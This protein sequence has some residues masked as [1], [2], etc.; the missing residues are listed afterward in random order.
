[1][2]PFT[3]L[4]AAL[5]VVVAA[6]PVAAEPI[7]LAATPVALNPDDPA[8]REVGDLVYRGGFELVS[9]DP[10]F[11]GFSALGVSADGGRMVALS[12][13]GT[14]LAARLTYDPD[15][16]LSG[17][18]EPDLVPLTD[19][20]GE[21]LMGQF[22]TDAE[23]MAP[24]VGGEIIVS[25]E[26]DHRLWAY[27][28]GETR[29]Q[30]IRPPEGIERLPQRA[31]IEALTLLDDGRLL[32]LA[33]GEPERKT[34]IA[35]VS[36]R[37]GWEVMTYRLEDG[38]LPTGAATLANG[39]VLVLERYLA[40]RGSNRARIRRL[41][42]EAFEPGAELAGAE[43]ATIGPPRT[44]DNFEGIETRRTDDGRTLI[45]LLSDDNFNAGRQRTLLFMFELRP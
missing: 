22:M 25:F 21:A 5:L 34:S 15:G 30:P 1:M 29:A 37:D 11:G 10:R 17:L 24:G 4:L 38:F 40:P 16:N 14:S 27:P 32:A 31:G 12:D 8:D 6:P 23:G 28:P 35:W 20:R 18:A 44:V 9:R 43:I 39:D 42:A 45:Y 19:P 36:S 33:E 3:G 26:R 13:Q 7:D 41:P 2:R